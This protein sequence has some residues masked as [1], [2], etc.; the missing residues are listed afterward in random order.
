MPN[1]LRQRLGNT[2]FRIDLK[3]MID[4]LPKWS[5]AQP[6]PEHIRH[7]YIR[8]SFDLVASARVTFH[9]HTQLAQPLRPPPD[10][11]ARHANLP[12]DF[13]AADDN[14]GIVGE[15]GQQLIDAPV[16]GAGKG[17]Q[18]HLGL[19]AYPPCAG[20]TRRLRSAAGAE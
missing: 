7:K 13:P 6:L 19:S 14:H 9:L 2:P 12:R 18:R 4:S 3:K 1:M 16:G 11:G 5:I 17:A 8:H 20:S 15:K 10:G